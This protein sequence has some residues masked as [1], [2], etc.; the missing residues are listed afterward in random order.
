[1]P[2]SRNQLVAEW[3]CRLAAA[4]DAQAGTSGRTVWLA[5]LQLRL[6]RFLISLYGTGDW[7]TSE[8]AACETDGS[9]SVVFDSPEVLPLAGK[10]AK[11]AGKIRQVLKAVSTAQDEPRPSGPLIGG[12]SSNDWM[13]VAVVRRRRDQERCASLLRRLKFTVRCARLGAK[14]AV[15]VPAHEY[16]AAL[17]LLA[18]QD[19]RHK[20]LTSS[21]RGAIDNR[22]ETVPP[23]SHLMFWTIIVCLF[24][25]IPAMFAIIVTQARYPQAQAGEFTAEA[26]LYALLLFTLCASMAFVCRI[27]QAVQAAGGLVQRTWVTLNRRLIRNSMDRQ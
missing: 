2:L 26:L 16:R 21:D 12:L 1:M 20:L 17:L 24:A 3:Q 11:E 9:Q 13:T 10:P 7:R 19:H 25:P 18:E 5:R 4:E 22:G 15:E 27:A 8:S 6:Y 23:V 14:V